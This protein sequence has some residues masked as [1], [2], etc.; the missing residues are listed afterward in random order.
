MERWTQYFQER[1][2]FKKRKNFYSESK[3]TILCF[4]IFPSISMTLGIRC[5]LVHIFKIADLLIR[6]KSQILEATGKFNDVLS[7]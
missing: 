3:T 1:M 7:G 4:I 5:V 2:F 6:S